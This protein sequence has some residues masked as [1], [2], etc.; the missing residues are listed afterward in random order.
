MNEEKRNNIQVLDEDIKQQAAL[1]AS[2]EEI[3]QKKLEEQF[4]TIRKQ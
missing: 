1:A 2:R 3:L 4:I